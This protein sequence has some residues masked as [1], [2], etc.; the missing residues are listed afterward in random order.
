MAT[1][2]KSRY[3][4]EQYLEMERKAAHKSEYVAGEIVAMSGASEQ[5]VWIVGTVLSALRGKLR[6]GPCR[7]YASDLRVR[8][9][10]SRLFTYP[11]IVVYCGE[12][13]FADDQSDTL[14]NPTLIV[15]V[16]SKSTE[17]YDRGKKFEYYRGI[18][19]LVEYVTISQDRAHV[20]HWTRRPDNRWLLEDTDR[21]DG[22]LQL[23]SV[24]CD[25]SLAE[26]YEGVEFPELPPEEG[27][28]E[29]ESE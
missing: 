5:H 29:A 19:S 15:E 21:L 27:L 14:L 25:L 28:L 1:H 22:V 2:P 23:S 24:G 3:T 13:A 6:G 16:L 7:T 12:P 11:D 20:E 9:S 8:V 17:S 4:P 10:S 18:E 26:I